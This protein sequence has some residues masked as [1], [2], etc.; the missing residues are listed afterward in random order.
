MTA[1]SKSNGRK[2]D[3]VT[4]KYLFTIE[5]YTSATFL[6]SENQSNFFIVFYFALI[7]L[8]FNQL[9]NPWMQ[10]PRYKHDYLDSV[11]R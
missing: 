4:S 10:D 6:L 11:Q 7:E 2:S 1:E 3:F 9:Q 5:F 8:D